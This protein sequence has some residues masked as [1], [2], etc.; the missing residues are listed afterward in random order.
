MVEEFTEIQIAS[1]QL[2]A[3]GLDRGARDVHD[4]RRHS[5]HASECLDEPS[6][7]QRLHV[8]DVE[9]LPRRGWHFNRT[10]AGLREI[11]Y[12]YP[13]RLTI[14]AIRQDDRTPIQQA[15]PEKRLPIKRLSR[16]VHEWRTKGRDG[17]SGL[18]VHAEERPLAR[19]LVLRVRVGKVVRN[20]RVLLA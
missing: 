20:Q 15:V 8:R 2:T 9:R 11:R 3:S 7:R 13:L 1:D 14:S 17:K 4:R 18:G 6:L 5:R 16:S 10:D 12:E 19:G